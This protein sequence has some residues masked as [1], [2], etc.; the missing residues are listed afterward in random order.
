MEK[1]Y[2]GLTIFLLVRRNELRLYAL[3]A[4]L[5][6]L[7]CQKEIDFSGQTPPSQL[8][9]NC[10]LNPDSVLRV[11]VSYTIPISAS[12]SDIDDK[13]EDAKRALVLIRHADSTVYDTLKL[14]QTYT[15]DLRFLVFESLTG[16]KPLL[17]TEYFLEVSEPM[18]PNRKKMRAKTGIPK[19]L[20]PITADTFSPAR[21]VT[22]D[23]KTFKISVDWQDVNP[24][25]GNYY[26]IEAVYKNT[27]Q[28]I[29][30]TELIRS[31]LYAL[32]LSDNQDI[33]GQ[34]DKFLYIFVDDAR[35]PPHIQNPQLHTELAV[36]TAT[37]DN[38]KE[39]LGQNFSS[40]LLIR[41]HHVSTELYKYY[42]E[43]EQYRS[44]TG[45]DIFAQPVPVHNN[46]LEGLGI[47]GAEV[48]QEYSIGLQ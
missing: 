32:Q 29:G 4:I 46:A 39:D 12:A 40:E 3:F 37:F 22:G 33:G 38:W 35:L 47:M 17:Q 2:K 34:N 26:I 8:Y 11:F 45:N 18:F 19:V 13:L 42:K 6:V 16:K 48:I 36:L 1:L 23:D 31:E 24:M 27:N 10:I 28:T 14:V 30:Q 9:A 7:S 20:A 44:H 25:L 41:V 15:E 5:L 21:I 43:V